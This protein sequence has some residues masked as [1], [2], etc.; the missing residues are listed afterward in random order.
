MVLNHTGMQIDGPDHFE[1]WK[2]GMK[3]LAQ[4]PNVACKI[5][6]VGM[7]IGPRRWSRSVLM[8]C[9]RSRRLAWT[10]AFVSNFPVDRLFS[11]YDKLFDAFN[12]ITSGFPVGDRRKLFHDNAARFYRL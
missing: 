4:A 6:G 5:S 11:S 9:L 10:A 2:A 1:A 12:D 8:C 7:G 3:L